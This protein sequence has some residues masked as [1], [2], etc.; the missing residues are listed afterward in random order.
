MS[1]GQSKARRF[2]FRQAILIVA[3]LAFVASAHAEQLPVKTFTIADG[4]AHDEIR[5]IKRDSHGFLWLCTADGLSRFDGYRFTN[6]NS[7]DGLVSADINDLL[8]SKRSGVYWMATNGGG[9]IRFDPAAKSQFTT[10]NK[11]EPAN[12]HQTSAVTR[13]FTNY[14]VGDDPKTNIVIVLYQDRAGRIWAGTQGGLFRLDVEIGGTNTFQLIEMNIPS[15]TD[16]AVEVY[17]LSEDEEGSLWMGTS[18]GV[19]RRLPDGRN[20]HF[21]LDSALTQLVSTL[22]FDNQG[23]LWI[24]HQNGVLVYKPEPARDASNSNDDT[25]VWRASNKLPKT[26][27]KP[28]LGNIDL[29]SVIGD[30]VRLTVAN[31]LADKNVWALFKSADGRMFVGTRGGGLSE[32]DG[33]RFRNYAAAQG[34]SNRINAL[35]EDADGNLWV[36]TQANGAM[37]I[38]GNGLLSYREPDGLGSGDIIHIFENQARELCIISSKWTINR[39]DGEMFTAIRPNLPARI[40]DSS[41]G[42]WW[43][44]QDHAG[45]WWV[46]SN[47]GLYRF[48]KVKRLEELARAQPVAVYTTREGLADNNISRIFEDSRG[49]IW[50]SSYTPPVMLT[51]WERKT[52]TFHRYT[53]ADGLPGFN[54]ANVFGEDAAGNLWMG[55]HNGGM[56]RYRNG[57]F[58]LFGEKDGV[59]S[60]LMQGLHRDTHNRLWI[61][62]SAGG[63]GRLDDPAA[64]HPRFV[65]YTIKEGLSSNKLRSFTE[66]AWGHIYLGTARGVDRLN[67]ADGRVKHY[68][69]ADGLVNS[70]VTAA[71]RDRHGGLWFGTR[72]GVSHLM[73]QPD[74][75]SSPPH[76]L[77]SGLRV[78]GN[79]YAL[80]DLGEE[81]VTELNLDSDE[82]QIQIDFF[83]LEM[84]AGESLRYQYKLEGASE[85]WSAPM[86]QRTINFNLSP[87][88]YRFL[89]RAIADDGV[90]SSRPASVSFTISRPVWQRPWFLL[91]AII[92]IAAATYA[93]ARLRVRR[94]IELERV[95]TRIATD[96]H[97]DIGS[98]LSQ[99]AILSEVA[100][101]QS[102]GENK[103]VNEPLTL[104][105]GASRELV[106]SMSDIVWAINPH[107]DHLRDLTQRMRLFAS[108]VLTASDVDFTF[109]APDSE[110]D[111]QLGADVRREVF[112]I[113][114]ECINNAVKHSACTTAEIELKLEHDWLTLKISDNGNGFDAAQFS[115]DAAASVA[116][117]A[118]RGGNGLLNMRRRAANLG[119]EFRIESQRVVGGTIA[120]LKIPVGQRRLGLR[121]KKYLRK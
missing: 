66:D 82:R 16:R 47:A 56:A 18:Q 101:K 5:R 69:T 121:R 68:T 57:R 45:E 75:P 114:K 20:Q 32:F 62:T 43:I 102:D 24:G 117:P 25:R 88:T 73:P 116:A 17:A 100:R 35:I 14:P 111:L 92:L 40:L 104:I 26:H 74:R 13:A 87:G 50:I 65:S 51:R 19:V 12:F 21:A 58:E 54:W 91:T 31:G 8:E 107:K 90:V 93:I 52:N 94:L 115:G 61:A 4:L 98:G 49:D 44:I 105:A 64:E 70:E 72:E 2:L 112:L 96:L 67:L 118:R 99:I 71:F 113:Y 85:D 1:T 29:P 81:D 27:T 110:R 79:E 48:P 80:S 7:K 119:G 34:L 22:A 46:A 15:H 77:I 86:S 11:S 97:D 108:D 103:R 83:G 9:V 30:V 42:R 53:E 84:S 36:G 6:Y 37:K 39:F 28:Q 109:R 89:V 38:N 55:M 59:P 63:A 76:V 33:V 41:S 3:L 120:T 106:D 60:G 95:R 23:R 10:T 78:N